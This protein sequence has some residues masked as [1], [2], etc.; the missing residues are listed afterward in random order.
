MSERIAFIL[1]FFAA[2]GA[3]LMAGLF[4]TFSTFAMQALGRIPADAGIRAMQEINVT[5]Q[6]PLFFVVF[7]GTPLLGL[8]LGVL[9]VAGWNGASSAFML[10]GA[11]L[12][13]V[14]TFLVTVVFNVPM[15]DTLASLDPAS[16]AGADYW[17]QYLARWTAWNHVRTATS[18][19]ALACFIAALSIKT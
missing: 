19:A 14:G 9:A 4:F 5:I 16:G 18:L 11:V 13:V 15:N 17:R 8:V 7:F 10:A 2:I 6:N 3:G 12:Y 1:T